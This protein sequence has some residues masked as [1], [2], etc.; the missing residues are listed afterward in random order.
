MNINETRMLKANEADWWLIGN[1][2]INETRM[3]KAQFKPQ[4]NGKLKFTK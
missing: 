1:M 3:L 2:N 4:Y